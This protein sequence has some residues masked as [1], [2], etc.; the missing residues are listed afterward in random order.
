[1]KKSPSA[2]VK[3]DANI[4]ESMFAFDDNKFNSFDNWKDLII[5]KAMKRERAMSCMSTD[6]L[7]FD[8]PLLACGPI[9]PTSPVVLFPAEQQQQ[10]QQS[11]QQQQ[12]YI[13]TLPPP[14]R[15][16]DDSNVRIGA[17]TKEERRAIIEKFRAK[18]RRRVWRKQI[19][20]DCR[21]RLA[22]TRPRVKGRF[23][24]RGADGDD[25]DTNL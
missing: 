22:D 9:E 4:S 19:K 12:K 5:S 14:P 20:Y 10:Q 17:Y 6:S 23:V 2:P 13:Y 24:S 21:K 25:G 3:E 7:K 16:V 18:K 15:D 11:Q 1:M 8:F